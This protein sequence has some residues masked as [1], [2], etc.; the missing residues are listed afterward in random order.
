[1]KNCGGGI[2]ITTLYDDHEPRRNIIAVR[3]RCGG[4]GKEWDH[5]NLAAALTAKTSSMFDRE[6]D[7]HWKVCTQEEA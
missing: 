7:K 6:C 4:C 3:Y 1:M 2:T 5:P